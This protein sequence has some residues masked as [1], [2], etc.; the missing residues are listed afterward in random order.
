[1]SSKAYLKIRE[2]VLNGRWA[3]E[4]PILICRF[5][6]QEFSSIAKNIKIQMDGR[7]YHIK[8]KAKYSNQYYEVNTKITKKIKLP[9]I[10]GNQLCGYCKKFVNLGTQN[11]YGTIQGIVYHLTCKNKYFNSLRDLTK[12]STIRLVKY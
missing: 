10:F 11:G 6:K 5:C 1:M 9:E 4:H 2:Q 7:A 12:T 3:K 8:C